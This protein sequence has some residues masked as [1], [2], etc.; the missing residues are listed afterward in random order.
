MTMAED[1]TAQAAREQV[2]A[3]ARGELALLEGKTLFQLMELQMG[4]IAK[5]LPNKNTAD[6]ERYVRVVQTLIRKTPKLLECSPAS[7]FGAVLTAAQLGL[8]FGP[9]QQAHLIPYGKECTL[10]IGYP[11]WLALIDRNSTIASVES[12]T[13]R[14]GDV[15][16][17]KFGLH[18]ELEHEIAEQRG[19]PTH[20]YCIIRR[21][22]G[23]VYFDVM[24]KAEVEKHRD[25]YGKK[26]GQL[27]GPWA[28]KDQFEAM[29]WKT[30][31]LR[32]KRWVPTSA[33]N[34]VVPESVDGRIIRRM[35]VDEAP[36]IEDSE[37]D[38]VEG[39]IVGED[40]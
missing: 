40:D 3:A 32:T 35:T 37:D 33:V 14:Q 11:G 16:H 22:N 21:T 24:T 13:V 2:G 12:H 36:V 31:F 17:Y 34:N 10:V 30:V 15:F 39:E 19:E 4:E 20:Y 27:K 28:D 38:V 23:G 1:K 18:P 9:T 29:A 5:A 26:G 7:F 8:D 6:A 25:R